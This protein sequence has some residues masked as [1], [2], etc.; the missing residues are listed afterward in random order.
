MRSRSWNLYRGRLFLALKLS[1]VGMLFLV[2]VLIV[3]CGSP[4]SSTAGLG[5]PPVTLTINLN[6]TFAS[7]TPTMPAY[8]CAAW[9]TQTSP[10]YYQN[11]IVE[12]YAKYVQNSNGNPVGMGGATA[13]ATVLW[14][15]GGTTT[16]N[17]ATTSDGL[18]VFPVP[19]Q[20]SAVGHEVLVAVSFTSQDGQHR[21][22]VTGSQDAFF[23]PV[24]A[25]PT[26]SPTSNQNGGNPG[27]PGGPGGGSTT[28]TGSPGVNP[29]VS[30]TTGQGQPPHG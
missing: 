9:A 23:V 21:C 15:F 17:V 2:S 30:P 4:P 6:Q 22:N 5:S 10:G 29:S 1:A 8:T 27:G 28:P 20:A 26:A 24:V 25:S 12:V 14:P 11:S 7:P 13:V 3:S 19:L 18:A 16:I